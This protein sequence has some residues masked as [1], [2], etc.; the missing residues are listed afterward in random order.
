VDRRTYTF[1]V[2]SAAFLFFYLSLR[3]LLVPPQ[4]PP[5]PAAED[6]VAAEKDGGGLED[7]AEPL[8]SEQAL[9]DAEDRDSEQVASTAGTTE[10]FTLGSMDPADNH[11]LLIT[12][13]NRGGAIERIEL[14]A[15]DEDGELAYRRV[16][17]RSGYLGYFAG[18]SSD[19]VDGMVVQ[20]VGP[21][22]PAALAETEAGQ[23]G[24][25]VGDVIVA[26]DG[27]PV[28]S[29]DQIRTVLA[30][31]KPG[32]RV[33]VEVLRGVTADN[34]GNPLLFQAT[35]SQHPL[36]LV[37]LAEDGGEDQIS[38]NVDRLSCLMTL[39]QVGRRGIPTGQR[40]LPSMPEPG[41]L[42]WESTQSAG[43]DGSQTIVFETTVGSDALGRINGQP[44]RMKR[45]FT[46]HPG[47]FILDMDLEVTNLGEQPQTLAYRLEGPNGITS[48]GWW[49]STKISP[50]W[51]S[52]AAARDIVY[53]TPADGH[54]LISGMELLEE[55]RSN[56][57]D[58]Y[59]GIFAADSP[60][61][62]RSMRYIGVDAQ[63]FA[64]AYLPPADQ[65][66][67]TDYQ[68]A[69]ALLVADEVD[70]QR[71]KEQAVNVSF[72]LSGE[73]TEVAPGQSLKQSMRLFAGPKEPALLETVGMGDTV[74]YGMFA[75]FSKLLAGLLHILQGIV[76]NYAL[77]IVLL[78][79]IVRGLMFPLSR[80]AAVNAQKMQELAP[81]MKKI[82]EKYKD[83]MEGRLKAQQ[84]LQK[85]VGFNPLAGCLPMFLQLPIF[86]GLYRA[87]SVDIDLRQKPLWSPSG[88]AS[89]LAGPDQ[90]YYWGDWMPDFIAGRG[91]GWLGPYL[92]ILPI[93]VVALFITQQKLFMP[94][95]TDE[96]TRMTQKV[97]NFMTLF[98]GILFFKVP[99]GLCIY[100]IAS[101]LWGIGERV[102]VKRTLPSGKHFN[103]DE[104][105]D[106]IDAVATN[107][108]SSGKKT[109]AERL[110]DQVNQKEPEQ[111]VERPNKRRRPPKKKK[112]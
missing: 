94:P 89:N 48:E 81:E 25:R 21:G 65:E 16:D 102:L 69:S 43:P 111:P 54:Q 53:K 78:T 88:W 9:A 34:E 55:T 59:L 11:N 24:I 8:P 33:S 15:R 57:K 96:Q 99:A 91:T 7:A 79:V 27:L 67:L 31:T 90:F 58:P 71:H 49:Y 84:A 63:Y 68:R 106:V 87:L 29:D 18:E 47:S 109:L 97:M 32:E 98:M 86:M 14:T 80:N 46:V 17:T 13:R 52:G 92:N 6:G 103:L 85:R 22:T 75:Y 35:L 30:E 19:F 76:G 45:S 51:F 77:A 26:V 41:S 2:A 101:S 1:I 38:G 10:W 62:A 42:F 95:A 39:A 5:N 64:V 60:Q 37:R 72:F 20:V 66:F 56:P 61:A 12:F 70:V 83:D 4:P 3:A 104:D 23:V 50:N 36:D 107:K 28:S 73:A 44:V 110:I 108:K 40:A 74:Y 93:F 100:F 105:G 82:A 112:R